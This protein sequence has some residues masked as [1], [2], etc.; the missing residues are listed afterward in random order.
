MKLRV[1][2]DEVI[3]ALET[4]VWIIDLKG[5]YSLIFGKLNSEYISLAYGKKAEDNQFMPCFDLNLNT[6]LVPFKLEGNFDE[7]LKA[8]VVYQLIDCMMNYLIGYLHQQ[9]NSNSDKIKVMYIKD[10]IQNMNEDHTIMAVF[11]E[12]IITHFEDLIEVY[13]VKCNKTKLSLVSNNAPKTLH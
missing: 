5:D 12:T 13:D 1:K 6:Y 3:N 8:S 9:Q 7:E 2:E 11:A 10:L 4:N